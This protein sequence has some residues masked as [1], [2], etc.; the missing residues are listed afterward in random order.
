MVYK[1]LNFMAVPMVFVLSKE[2]YKYKITN[3]KLNEN[4]TTLSFLWIIPLV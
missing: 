1:Q 2:I 4:N 3:N